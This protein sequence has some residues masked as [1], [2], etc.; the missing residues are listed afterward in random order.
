MATQHVLVAL[1]LCTV[2]VGCSGSCPEVLP[3]EARPPAPNTMLAPPPTEARAPLREVAFQVG[4]EVMGRET[5]AAWVEVEVNGAKAKAILD[6]GAEANVVQAWFLT[7][8][9]LSQEDLGNIDIKDSTG[10]SQKA[11]V[12]KVRGTIAGWGE[13]TTPAIVIPTIEMFES[14]G[15]GMIVNPLL[16]SDGRA[17]Q[18]DFPKRQLRELAELSPPAGEVIETCSSTTRF[19]DGEVLVTNRQVAHVTVAGLDTALAVDS[20]GRVTDVFRGSDAGEAL[21]DKVSGSEEAAGA[22]GTQAVAV[23]SDAVAV[24][25]FGASFSLTGVRLSPTNKERTSCNEE[26]ILGM[27][28]LRHSN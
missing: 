25:V 17:V 27:D 2:A 13:V 15:V 10:H 20:G 14:V 4:L 3:A 21:V 11:S 8:A 16:L 24:D 12:A 23:V 18:L 22:L 5:N 26:G 19:A 28:V 7:A 1:G 9:K 6:T